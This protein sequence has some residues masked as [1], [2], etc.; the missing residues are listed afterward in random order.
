MASRFYAFRVLSWHSVRSWRSPRPP[1]WPWQPRAPASGHT[2][3]VCGGPG[4]DSPASGRQASR[5]PEG[6]DVCWSLQPPGQPPLPGLEAAPTPCGH[7][8]RGTGR[9][10]CWATSL[11][12]SECV[13]ESSFRPRTQP[14]QKAGPWEAQLPWRARPR[15]LFWTDQEASSAAWPVSKYTE[16]QHPQCGPPSTGSPCP[17]A[18]LHFGREATRGSCRDEGAQDRCHQELFLPR[19]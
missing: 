14:W 17:R 6:A 3:R 15:V 1:P 4:R 8:G 11:R 18:L 19:G 5:R 12:K 10:V 9:T 7:V 2:Q 13:G 16:V